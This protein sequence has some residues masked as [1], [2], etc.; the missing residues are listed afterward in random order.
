MS[1]V[2][3]SYNTMCPCY[4]VSLQRETYILFYY[5]SRVNDSPIFK[6]ETGK[7]IRLAEKNNSAVYL[8]VNQI[9]TCAEAAGQYQQL[10]GRVKHFFS[11]GTDPL[12]Q[13]REKQAQRE[14]KYYD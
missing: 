10:G 3:G 11:F 1:Y 14:S 8:P 9:P 6:I 2:G 4:F 7:P 13:S 5:L 12:R